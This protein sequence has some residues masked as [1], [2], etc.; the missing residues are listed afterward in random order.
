[1]TV[2]VKFALSCKFARDGR[3]RFGVIL[4]VYGSLLFVGEFILGDICKDLEYYLFKLL[5]LKIYV[6]DYYLNIYLLLLY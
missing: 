6:Y 2:T 3:H 5:L 1:M 4:G